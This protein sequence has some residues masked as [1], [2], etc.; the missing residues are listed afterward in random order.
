MI[1]CKEITVEENIRLNTYIN[2]L[3]GSP[4]LLDC[5]KLFEYLRILQAK[6]GKAVTKRALCRK[7]HSDNNYI[8]AYGRNRA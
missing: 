1:N 3:E 5:E 4:K 2:A 6:Y 8:A 7:V